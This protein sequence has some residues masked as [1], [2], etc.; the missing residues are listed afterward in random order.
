VQRLIEGKYPTLYVAAKIAALTG[1]KSAYI[2][3][4]AFDKEF[5][6]SLIIKF[7][8]QYKSASRQEIDNLL[9]DKLSDTLDETQKR[10]K[11][12]NLLFEMSKKDESIV[13]AG[14]SKRPKW[15][16]T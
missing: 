12:N 11:I 10:K 9:M 5:Y 15:I 3:N 8:E 1:D 16:L 6:K 14:S 7:L 2:K 13:N 4:R